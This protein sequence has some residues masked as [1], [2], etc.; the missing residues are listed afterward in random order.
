MREV[1]YKKADGILYPE[2]IEEK[3]RSKEDI[4]DFFYLT[5]PKLNIENAK[6]ETNSKNLDPRKALGHYNGSCLPDEGCNAFIFGH[7]S[8]I[9][10]PNHY[11]EGDYTTIFSR[12]GELEYGDEFQIIYKGK[13]YRYVISLTKVQKPED[14]NPLGNP[15]PASIGKHES[16]VELFSCTPPGTTKFR[17]SVVGKLVL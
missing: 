17:L 4:P 10:S 5:I 11:E 3:L 6:V 9:G 15:I 12:L 2:F 1:D 8:Y 7:S 14:V 16:T 13:T